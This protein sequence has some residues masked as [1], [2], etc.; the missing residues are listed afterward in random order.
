MARITRWDGLVGG[1][2]IA[3]GTTQ[4][5]VVLAASKLGKGVTIAR[6]RGQVVIHPNVVGTLHA[7]LAFGLYL[8]DESLGAAQVPEP[9][10]DFNAD[11]LFHSTAICASDTFTD[12]GYDRLLVD[13]RSMRRVQGDQALWLVAESEAVAMNTLWAFRILLLLP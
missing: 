2:N 7:K 6:V 11:W 4:I 5:Q 3:A 12:G 13:N 8:G 10:T 1:A 9:L